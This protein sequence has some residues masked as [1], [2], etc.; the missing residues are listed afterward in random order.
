MP[1]RGL[2]EEG[3]CP[4]CK[5]LMQRKHMIRDD[6]FGIEYSYWECRCGYRVKNNGEE[7]PRDENL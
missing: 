3:T 1:D 7:I 5:G 6:G 4:K 2:L